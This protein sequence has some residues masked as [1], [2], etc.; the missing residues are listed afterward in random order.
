[1]PLLR[2]NSILGRPVRSLVAISTK[3]SALVKHRSCMQLIISK[4]HAWKKGML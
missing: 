4:H 2:I 3:L 1:M